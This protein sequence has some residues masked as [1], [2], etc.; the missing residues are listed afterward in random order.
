MTSPYNDLPVAAWAAK[1]REL[2]EQHPLDPNEIYEVVIQVWSEIFQSRITNKGYRIGVD[3]FP[4]PQI[5]GFFLHELIPLELSRR[6]LGG[7]R[8]DQNASEKDIV[9][10]PDNYFS[11]EI[12]TSS[13]SRS[14]YGN[15]SYAQKSTTE[16]KG[17]KDKS[18]YYLVVNFQKFSTQTQIAQI[19]QI[20]LVRFGWIDRDDWQGQAA[21]TGQQARL[22]PDIE[23]Y[24]LLTLPL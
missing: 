11:I 22:S 21:A 9:Y 16:L 17:K 14:T 20:N 2:I 15:R 1:T 3:L 12:K 13:S 4:S 23:R 10:I 19:P 24:K 5:M 8:R 18:G 6:Y 7:W